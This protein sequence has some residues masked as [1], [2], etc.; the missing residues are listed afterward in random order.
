MIPDATNL[1]SSKPEIKLLIVDDREDNLMSIESILEADG[2][3]IRKASSGRAAL[4]ILLKEQDFSLILM[5]VQM[6]DLNGYETASLIY[7]RDALKRIPIVFITAHGYGEGDFFKGY[8]T[9]GVD[10]IY[11][12]I[13]PA[14]LRAKVHVF[15]DLFT[16]THELRVNEQKLIAANDRL[17]REIEERIASEQRV[18]TLNE[19]L[20][21]N[22]Q[23][24][25][26]A[27]QE[28]ENTNQELERFAY[29]ASHDLQEPLRK[30]IV[31]GERLEDRF[32][33][34]L[35]DEGRDYLRRMTRASSR[36]QGLITNLLSFSRAMNSAGE[37]ERVD[38]QHLL[39]DIISDLEI[40]IEQ[41]QATVLVPSLPVV[42]GIPSLIRQ[43]FQ[44]LIINALKFS[45]PER[46]P[47]IT[48]SWEGIIGTEAG[49]A[50]SFASEQNFCR[51]TVQDNGIGFDNVYAEQIFQ[52]FKRLHGMAEYEGTGIGLSICK[53]IVEKHCGW[54]KADGKQDQ[55]ACFTICLP[56]VQPNQVERPF[57][58]IKPAESL[59]KAVVSPF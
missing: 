13:N 46:P 29:V 2:Y 24:L 51:I 8:Q 32:K 50:T 47:V 36:M 9:G 37:L 43:L 54:I 15:V 19:Q 44:N 48:I 52:A 3:T 28:L 21:D 38:L 20:V 49:F 59:S 41:K 27:N 30:I 34:A 18:K 42:E 58:I 55:G 57:Y 25:E 31:F 40:Q 35:G 10:Y 33:D 17:E 7:Q 53:K 1:L 6:P 39:Q 45:H 22:I 11:K 56:L 14:L 26:L 5:D 16:K 12:P 23:Q 4:K